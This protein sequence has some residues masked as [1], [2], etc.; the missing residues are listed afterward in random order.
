ML[1]LQP[2]SMRKI[3]GTKRLHN[4]C[5]DK[6][7][8]KIG[9]LYTAS[10]ISTISNKIESGEFIET[11]FH[12]AVK[13]NPGKFGLPSYYE[14][15]PIIVSFTAADKD[16]SIQ[17]HPTDDYAKEN[18]NVSY[19]K[20][21]SWYFIDEPNEG[22]IYT[23]SKQI[24]KEIIDQKM[25]A[26]EFED[27]IDQLNVKKGDLVFIPSGTLHALT[28]GSLVYEIQQSTDITYRFYD[29]DRVDID[30]NKREL[31]TQKAIETLQPEQNASKMDVKYNKGVLVE[32][33][34]LVL[35]ELENNYH[36]DKDIAQILTVIDGNYI[37]NNEKIIQGMSVVVFPNEKLEV[38]KQE[39]GKVMIATPHVF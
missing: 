23:G 14:E 29:F 20:S 26:G 7:M 27:V 25:N 31:H 17:V 24:D 6:Q 11:D 3:W 19:G 15:F 21:E 8:D 30:G 10:G 18:E 34:T 9:L 33:Y 39:N 4:Y 32:P 12:S 16:L 38:E 1:I 22:W 13:N 5:G 37:I 28:A 36:N 35:T 2:I